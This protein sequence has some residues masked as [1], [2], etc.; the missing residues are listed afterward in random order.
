[1]PVGATTMWWYCGICGFANHP[2]KDQDNTRCEQCGA[3]S[4]HPAA[5]DYRP[6]GA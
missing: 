6:Q 2:R 4:S 3:R 1:M 5:I